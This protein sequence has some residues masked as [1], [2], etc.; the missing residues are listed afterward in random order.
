ML[1]TKDYK[2]QKLIPDKMTHILYIKQQQ[3]QQQHKQNKKQNKTI[4]NKNK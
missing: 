4:Q 1:S 3:Q 2:L